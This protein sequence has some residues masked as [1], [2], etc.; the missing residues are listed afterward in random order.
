VVGLARDGR[1]DLAD[2]ARVLGVGTIVPEDVSSLALLDALEHAAGRAP[3]RRPAATVLPGTVLTERER[4][5]LRL[6]ASGMSNVQIADEMFLSVNTVKTYVRSAYKKIH[7]TSRSGAILWA[8]QYNA[9]RVITDPRT[10][11]PG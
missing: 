7:V 1:Q 4:D 9:T 11:P 10:E 3:G 6:L 2:G 8:I 5:V